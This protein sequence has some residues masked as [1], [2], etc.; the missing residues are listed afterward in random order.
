VGQKYRQTLGN[1]LFDT[2]NVLFMCVMMF[3]FVYPFVNLFALSLNDGF[4]ALKGGIYFFPRKFSLSAYEMIFNNN[5]HLLQGAWWSVLRVVTATSTTLFATGLLSYIVTLKHFSGRKFLRTAFFLTMYFGG[6]LIP[7]YLLI[8]K[9]GLTNT[10]WVYILPGVF[11]AY[12]MLIMSSYIQNMPEAMFDSARID[13]AS[14]FRIYWAVV[15]PVAIPVFAAV[16]IYLAVSNWNSWFDVVLY[17]SNGDYDTLQVYLRRILTE[18]EGMNDIKDQQLLYNKFKSMTP[19][20]LRAATTM[21]V[22]IPILVVYPFFQ[23]YFIGGL[24]IGSVKG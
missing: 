18:A 16:S 4:D 12:F 8:V 10:F 6:G 2:A 14:E 20:T 5:S 17:N 24:T 3:I 13:G 15:I 7:T 1:R 22:V 11:N 23:K 9:L 21:V 19:A